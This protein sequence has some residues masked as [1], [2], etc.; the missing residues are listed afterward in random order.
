PVANRNRV[1]IEPLM[2]FFVNTLVLRTQLNGASS[3][4]ELLHQVRETVLGAQ[5]HQELPF[6]RLVQ[7]LAP[8]RSL[9]HAPLFQVMMTLDN[10]PERK[11]EL[12][13]L[14]LQSQGGHN[15]TAKF[16]LLLALT[17][18]R[19]A[20]K[21]VID[22]NA[23]LFDSTRIVRLAEHFRLLL[24]TVVEDPDQPI[25]QLPLLSVTERHRLL[26]EWN[27]T[28]TACRSYCI[29]ELFAEQVRQRPDAVAVVFDN[30]QISYAQLNARSN[31]LA[32]R[33]RQL[34]AGVES[35]VAI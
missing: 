5:G 15:A 23:D 31:D 32:H 4:R 21:G 12:P 10:S 28:E 8:E 20:L 22:Y 24:E 7:E 26:V 3:F 14:E 29:Q 2:G 9:S 6:E 35:S 27:D 13:Q 16:D 11:L 30:Q 25:A 33:L 18:K 34:G 1:E 17:T 19:N